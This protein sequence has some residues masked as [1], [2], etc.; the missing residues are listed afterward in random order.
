MSQAEII[1][2]DGLAALQA[3]RFDEARRHFERLVEQ[4]GDAQHWLLLSR[5]C[6]GAGDHA[7]EEAAVDEALAL[8]PHHLL[9]L[10]AKG[11]CL[12]Q[13]SDERGAIAFYQ[14]ALREAEKAGSLSAP[15][16]AEIDRVRGLVERAGGQFADHLEA[17]LEAADLAPATVS[18]RFGQ[19]IDILL[20][21]RTPFF[22]QPSLFYFAELPQRQF[23]EREEFPWVAGLEAATHAIRSELLAVLED[24]KGFEPYI[25]PLPNRPRRDFHGML[26]DPSWSAWYLV[27]GGQ[28]VEEHAD[29]C[30]RTMEALAG[31]PLTDIP[32]RTPSILFSLL[33]PGA[34]I[35]PHAGM[36]NCRLIGHLPLIVPPGCALRV[37]NET[38]AWE[39]GRTFIFDD[40]FEHEAWNRS[41]RLRVVL[42]F[43]IWRPELDEGERAAIAA[44]FRAID[45]YG[46]APPSES[47]S[48]PPPA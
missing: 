36:L 26:G 16:A 24:E 19:S 8:R 4:G 44:M 21:R 15:L 43:D 7:A 10:I 18:A 27:E 45:S 17:V 35:P 11:D 47:R 28:P 40:S 31:L 13:R 34:R 9:A 37:G 14:S 48:I 39:E 42:L 38:R 2:R 32:N 20:Q 46:A 25:K 3:G 1:A 41:D 6:R 5:A 33:R 22:Q 23:Y 12:A 29:R 30:P